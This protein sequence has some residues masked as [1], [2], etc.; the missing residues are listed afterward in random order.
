MVNFNSCGDK[1]GRWLK[2]RERYI[3]WGSWK[4]S[5]IY[6]SLTYTSENE[7][8]DIYYLHKYFSQKLN[9]YNGS[10]EQKQAK[11]GI[12]FISFTA[13]VNHP[14]L[15]E[16]MAIKYLLN[17]YIYSSVLIKAINTIQ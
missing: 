10:A 15:I 12:L 9:K 11:N 5:K 8:I 1:E 17:A 4:G 14:F 2:W 3:S 7:T 13:I 16:L 6:S